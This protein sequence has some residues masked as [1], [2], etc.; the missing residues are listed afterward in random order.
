MEILQQIK[1]EFDIKNIKEL[2]TLTPT[3][4]CEIKRLIKSDKF[5]GFYYYYFREYDVVPWIDPE[6]FD[7]GYIWNTGGD[8]KQKLISGFKSRCH[9]QKIPKM[10]TYV[11]KYKDSII[12]IPAYRSISK[13]QAWEVIRIMMKSR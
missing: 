10:K 1:D 8:I 4:W 11:H 12:L 5:D 7:T 13:Y 9:Y 2:K 3:K 6:T